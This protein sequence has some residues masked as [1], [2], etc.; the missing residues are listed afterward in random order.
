MN[1]SL[2][3]QTECS[4]FLYSP[5]VTQKVHDL[6]LGKESLQIFAVPSLDNMIRGYSKHYP[7]E[8]VFADVRWDPILILHS[9][10]STGTVFCG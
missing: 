2:L 9:S 3:E 5:E 4:K 10:G 1:L 7:Y 8:A 6:R